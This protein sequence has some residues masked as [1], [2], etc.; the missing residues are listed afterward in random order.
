MVGWALEWSEEI[1]F[2]AGGPLNPMC[3]GLFFWD[4]VAFSV[5]YRFLG[6]PSC[7]R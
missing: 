5:C 1:V 3:G 7:T 2:R 4:G 6:M